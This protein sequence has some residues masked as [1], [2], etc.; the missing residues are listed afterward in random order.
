MTLLLGRVKI[1]K[2]GLLDLYKHTKRAPGEE[3]NDVYKPWICSAMSISNGEIIK[4]VVELRVQ[5]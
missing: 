5:F 3:N 1:S 4:Q 2:R